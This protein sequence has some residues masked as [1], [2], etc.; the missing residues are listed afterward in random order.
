MGWFHLTQLLEEPLVSVTAI[1]EPFFL[2][3]GKDTPGAKAF[4]NMRITLQKE[5]PDLK[6]HASTS[7]LPD[8]SSLES[9]RKPELALVAGRTCDAPK[10]FSQLVAKGVTHVYLEKPGAENATQ[11]KLMQKLAAQHSVAVVVG[12]NKNVARYVRQGLEHLRGRTEGAV[13]PRV[14]LQH[15]NEFSPGAELIEFMTGPG[16]EGMLHNMCCHELALAVSIFGVT[17]AGVSRLTV[18]RDSS[19]LMELGD[20][21][22]DF[23]KLSFVLELAVPTPERPGCVS[24]QVG[25]APL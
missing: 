25:K 22:S 16:G 11:L 1:I 15:C 6:F 20:G 7:E 3:A 8:P 2:G 18:D 13:A 14:T 24:V 5:H 4:E 23:S 10:L 21:R 17:S 19:E 9:G 12:Y